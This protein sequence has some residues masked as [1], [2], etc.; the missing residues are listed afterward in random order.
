MFIVRVLRNR[1]LIKAFHIKFNYG[2]LSL[3]NLCYG[4]LFLL[5]GVVYLLNIG[6]AL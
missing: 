4:A 6:D 1:A 2:N 3:R 5:F